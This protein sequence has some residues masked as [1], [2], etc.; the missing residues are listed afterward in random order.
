MGAGI[1]TETNQDFT[2]IIAQTTQIC[3][4]LLEAAHLQKGDIL[5]VGCSSSEV[6]HHQIGSFSSAE[7]GDVIFTTLNDIL[8]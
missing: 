5:V 1:S 7:I 8:S 2:K 4:E 6:A 3:R